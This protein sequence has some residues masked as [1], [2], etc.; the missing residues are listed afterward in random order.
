M[1][2]RVGFSP[3]PTFSIFLVSQL[4]GGTRTIEEPVV[5]FDVTVGVTHGVDRSDCK[6]HFRYIEPCY[7]RQ[8]PLQ[9]PHHHNRNQPSTEICGNRNIKSRQQRHRNEMK[10][11]TQIQSLLLSSQRFF[12]KRR[13]ETRHDMSFRG[14]GAGMR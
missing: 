2:W 5:R 4:M 8:S 1:K 11:E 3:S 12:A 7:L 9:T 6:Y 13:S 14:S 10:D